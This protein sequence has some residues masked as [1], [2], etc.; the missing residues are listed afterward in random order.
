[1]YLVPTYLPT[2]FR[3]FF[4]FPVGS[5]KGPSF[6]GST[7]QKQDPDDH[8]TDHQLYVIIMM[9]IEWESIIVR[10]MDFFGSTGSW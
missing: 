1:M 2:H 10:S 6:R 5:S 4:F 9:M 3:A 8:V 7:R